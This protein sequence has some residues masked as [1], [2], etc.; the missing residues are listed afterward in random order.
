[1]IFE[2]APHVFILRWVPQFLKPA[3]LSA[4]VELKECLGLL[5]PFLASYFSTVSHLLSDQSQD[6]LCDSQGL[7]CLSLNLL[8]SWGSMAFSFIL[9]IEYS[10]P[11]FTW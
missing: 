6:P 2:Q 5:L 11:L 1:M 9:C 8:L 7:L 3:L 10:S 4:Q